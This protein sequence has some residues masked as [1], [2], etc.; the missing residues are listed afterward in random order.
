MINTFDLARITTQHAEIINR[1]ANGKLDTESVLRAQQALLDEGKKNRIRRDFMYTQTWPP[2]VPLWYRTP[3]QQLER[4]RQLWG[5]W[6]GV[7][8]NLPEPPAGF[9]AQSTTEVLLL[10]VPLPF[11]ELLQ[12]VEGPAG[13]VKAIE[14]GFDSAKLRLAP[15]I[16]VRTEPVWLAFEPNAHH[17]EDPETLWGQADLAA[18]EVLSALIQFP[19][20]PLAWDNESEFAP[21]LSGYQYWYDLRDEARWDVPSLH[22]FNDELQLAASQ[23]ENDTG[24]L[25]SPRVREC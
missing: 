24:E 17:G 19:D 14:R 25:G 20:W 8:T 6:H 10:H 1:I 21:Y 5:E 22:L 12:V 13:C 11:D 4:A 23:P 18:S 15:N 16:P 3:E 7:V 2:T 9:V